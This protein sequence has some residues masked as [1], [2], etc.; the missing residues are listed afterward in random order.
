M[1]SVAEQI[2]SLPQK[3]REEVLSDY[4]EEE[5][6][7]LLYDWRGFWSRPNQIAPEGDWDIWLILAGRGFGKT[8]SG[9]EWV[10]EQVEAG[11]KRIALVAETQKDLEKVMI[12]GDSGLATICP[13]GFIVK[14]TKKPVQITFATGAVALGYNATEPDQLRGPQFDAAWCDEIAK[15]RYARETWDQLQFGLRLGDKPR[16]CVTTTPRPIELMKSIVAKKEGAVAITKGKT[17]DNLS[18][19]AASFIKKIH[20]KYAGTRLGRQELDAEILGDIPNALWSL[21]KIDEYR[22][23]K[24]DRPENFRRIAVAVDPPAKGD[25]SSDECGIIVVAVSEDL[26]DGYVLED[27]SIHGSPAVWGERVVSAYDQ[28]E[29]DIIVAEV[30]QGGDMVEHVIRSIRNNVNF[31]SVHSYRGKH[32]RAEPVSSLYA[33]G[34][35]HHVGAFVELETQMTMMS[36][37]GYEGEKSPDRLDAL[38]HGFTLLFNLMTRK[39]KEVEVKDVKTRMPMA[40]KR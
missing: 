20:A 16:S 15:W 34:K 4:S 11:C 23:R 12:E 29:A 5:M 10:K 36:S 37:H 22:V 2:A 21:E 13:P 3:V 32:L 14:Y 33:R 8:R 18:N 24:S 27:A 40:R 35:I 28:W 39:K 6:A 25:E 38:V 19:L 30:N 31:K 26:E 1:Q 17:S 9:A 7:A